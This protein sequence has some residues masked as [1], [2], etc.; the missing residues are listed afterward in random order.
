MTGSD[1]IS[2]EIGHLKCSGRLVAMNDEVKVRFFKVVACGFM[3]FL[4]ME[5][6]IS[7]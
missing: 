1:I 2:S 5:V 7:I 4:E 6:V 3:R